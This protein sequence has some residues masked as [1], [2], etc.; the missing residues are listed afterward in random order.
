MS[1]QVGREIGG[2]VVLSVPHARAA[3]G[4]AP[5]WSVRHFSTR[6]DALQAARELT[7]QADGNEAF[8]LAV[9]AHCFSPARPRL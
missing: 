9:E 6:E 4:A 1:D 8:V 5:G 7:E 3:G 2:Y